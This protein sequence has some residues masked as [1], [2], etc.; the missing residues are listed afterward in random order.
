MLSLLA[1]FINCHLACMFCL[2]C[3]GI[4]VY[5]IGKVR[6]ED[7]SSF[8]CPVKHLTMT[9]IDNSWLFMLI[10]TFVKW[11]N[12][13]ASGSTND[14]Y[15]VLLVHWCLIASPRWSRPMFNVLF[16]FQL[17]Q[18]YCNVKTSLTGVL[19]FQW[20]LW[21][22]C[23]KMPTRLNQTTKKFCHLYSWHTFD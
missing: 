18:A 20:S 13:S 19:H 10:Y 6:P 17:L 7:V 21:L 12:N 15:F 5:I 3:M 16:L 9:T 14:R 4:V 22:I 2:L 1:K 11:A 23:T 8:D